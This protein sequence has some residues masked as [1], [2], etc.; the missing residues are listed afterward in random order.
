MDNLNRVIYSRIH[1]A[2]NIIFFQ[3][4]DKITINNTLQQVVFNGSIYNIY[5]IVTHSGS[6]I[7]TSLGPYAS[8]GHYLTY[9]YDGHEKKYY[10]HNDTYVTPIDKPF[11]IQ[12]FIIGIVKAT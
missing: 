6:N 2:P 5:T 9:I 8:C 7:S 11:T 4:F 12:N 3:I 1:K 10:M